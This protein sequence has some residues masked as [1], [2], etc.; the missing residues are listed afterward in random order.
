M[1]RPKHKR[2]MTGFGKDEIKHVEASIPEAQRA[3]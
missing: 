3:V 1:T 2:T